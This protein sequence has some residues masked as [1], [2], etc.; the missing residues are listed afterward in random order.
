M[1]ANGSCMT[2]MKMKL[3]NVNKLLP[4]RYGE[5][6]FLYPKSERTDKYEFR[7]GAR[8]SKER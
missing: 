1:A 4:L 6:V 7:T 5:A 2:A 8:R 3:K